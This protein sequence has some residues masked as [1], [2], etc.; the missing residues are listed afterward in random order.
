MYLMCFCSQDGDY[1]L[2]IL[3]YGSHL[4]ALGALIM[5]ARRDEKQEKKEKF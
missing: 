1:H 5:G 4:G 2:H 3:N